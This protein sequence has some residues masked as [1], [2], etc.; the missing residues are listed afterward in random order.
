M[1]NLDSISQELDRLYQFEISEYISR[2]DELK[3]SGYRI[4]RNESGQHK[5]V[6]SGQQSPRREEEYSYDQQGRTVSE[7][8]KENIFIRAKKKIVSFIDTIKAIVR[9]ARMINEKQRYFNERNR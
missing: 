2:C 9:I 6:L 8:K 1:V 5:V 3:R 4:Y 7:N